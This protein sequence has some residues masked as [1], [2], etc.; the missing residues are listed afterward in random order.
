MRYELRAKVLAA[1]YDYALTAEMGRLEEENGETAG[2]DGEDGA[3][4][5]I[6][7]GVSM[8]QDLLKAENERAGSENELAGLRSKMEAE[9]V[10]LNVL[11]NR[12]AYVEIAV[13]ARCREWARDFDG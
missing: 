5:V 6:G 3:G 8:Q 4:T 9:R 7:T 12:E 1:Y 13:P 10:A 11:L 2:I